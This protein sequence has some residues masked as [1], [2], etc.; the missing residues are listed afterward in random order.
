MR[1][2]CGDA[3]PRRSTLA[4]GRLTTIQ[5]VTRAIR[6]HGFSGSGPYICPYR[7]AIG[8][9]LI[10]AICGLGLGSTSTE[11]WEEPIVSQ[12]TFRILASLFSLLVL[13]LFS[14]IFEE[15]NG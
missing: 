8:L 4:L 11:F 5:C 10:L 6:P 12:R 2:K 9:V 7:T 3:V 14:P 13:L 1:D 15:K